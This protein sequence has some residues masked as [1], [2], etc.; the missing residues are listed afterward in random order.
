ML[1]ET[2]EPYQLIE[3]STR[4]DDLQTTEYLRLNRMRGFRRSWM[5]T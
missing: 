1:E 5:A 4:A 3:K 2:G